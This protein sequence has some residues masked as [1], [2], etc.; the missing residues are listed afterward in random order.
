MIDLKKLIE[1]SQKSMEDTEITRKVEWKWMESGYF[2]QG[3]L[4][5]I[6]KYIAIGPEYK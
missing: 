3:L 5:L 4:F 6:L 1:Q 2:R